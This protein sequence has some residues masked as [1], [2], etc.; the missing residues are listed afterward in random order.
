[1]QTRAQGARTGEER[2][3]NADEYF[4]EFVSSTC[5]VVGVFVGYSVFS[6]KGSS[7]IC[8]SRVNQAERG[9]RLEHCAAT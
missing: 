9:D 7:P 3:S 6:G 2:W 5:A 4:C 8:T 1:M